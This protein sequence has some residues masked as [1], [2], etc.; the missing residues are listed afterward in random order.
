MSK[1]TL[2]ALKTHEEAEQFDLTESAK[3]TPLK[4]LEILVHLTDLQKKLPKQN[5]VT[6]E[7]N[8]IPVLRRS[9]K[10]SFYNEL[11]G[12]LNAHHVGGILRSRYVA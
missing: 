7:N 9:K 6:D 10:M 8:Q 2:M 1:R 4:R 3:A 12:A 11:I 5:I